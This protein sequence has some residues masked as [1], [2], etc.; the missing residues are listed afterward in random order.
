LAGILAFMV[1]KALVNWCATKA[2]SYHY[3]RLT[4]MWAYRDAYTF[5]WFKNSVK[6]FI[7]DYFAMMFAIAVNLMAFIEFSRKLKID[8]LFKKPWDK[9]NS[10]LTIVLAIVFIAIPSYGFIAIHRNQ[11]KLSSKK[12]YNKLE[13]YIEGIR[14]DSYHSSMFNVYFLARRLFSGLFLV[15]F[16]K[17]PMLQV[18]VLTISSVINFIY[19]AS[20]KPM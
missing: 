1:F 9:A 16:N 19:Q 10:I 2:P 15:F 11:G 7:E 20:E 8:E 5:N 17:Y 14:L 3:V 6:F 4:G 12:V 13:A 18:T